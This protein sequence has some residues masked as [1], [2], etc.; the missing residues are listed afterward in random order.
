M[1]YVILYNLELINIL[2]IQIYEKNIINL[3]YKLISEE[4]GEKKNEWESLG[5]ERE[6]E[7]EREMNRSK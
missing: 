5:W 2:H 4:M 6:R 3:H 7:R 1:Y